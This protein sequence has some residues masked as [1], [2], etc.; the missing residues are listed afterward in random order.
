VMFNQR[1]LPAYRKIKELITSGELGHIQR[2]NWTATHWFRSR[3]YYANG[4][5]RGTWKGEGGGVLINQ[6]PH[7]LDLWQWLFG[8]PSHIYA[9]C[10]IGRFHDIEVE[11]DVT[12]FMEYPD[13]KRGIF[14]TST[15]EAPGTNRLE[16]A[17]ERGRLIYEDNQLSF[18]RNE[19]PVSEFSRTTTSLFGRPPYWKVE[20]P[21]APPPASTHSLLLA[22][23]VAAILDGSALLA[24]GEE[25]IHSVELANAMLLSSLRKQKVELPIC[26]REFRRELDLLIANST[27]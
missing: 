5:W 25:G 4:G 20:I 12:A 22:D 8:M 13:G 14:V 10:G 26:G 19:I 15:G 23:F 11:D 1:T 9:D 24:P 27:R 16:I 2:I 3:A 21:L 7:Q 6:C 17:A 18:L